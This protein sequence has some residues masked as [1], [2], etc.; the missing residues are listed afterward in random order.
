MKP[1]S[2]ASHPDMMP[3]IALLTGGGDRPY[4]FGLSTS[5]LAS[6]VGIDFIGSDDLDFPEFRLHRN[7]KFFNL[8]GNQ[9]STVTLSTKIRRVLTY[10]WKLLYYAATTDTPIFHILWNNKFET[11][12]RTLLMS[13]YRCL[14]KKLILTV[15]NVNAGKR[16][17][18]DTWLNRATLRRQYRSADHLFV[19]TEMMKDELSRDFQ[20]DQRR[21]SVIPFGINNSI[22][23]SSMTRSQARQ[24]LGV[25]DS[26]RVLLFFGNIAPYKG[27]D[28][29]VEAFQYL[30]S[31]DPR[32]KLVI[33][34]RVDAAPDYWTMIQR[35]IHE[36][37]PIDRVIIKSSFIP[38]T[39]I[40]ALFKSADALLLPYRHIYQSGVLFLG[41]S[42]GLPA[43][44]ADVD[45]FRSE[46]INGETGFLFR[47]EDPIHLAEVV[48]QYFAS[49]LYANLEDRRSQ[50]KSYATARNSWTRVAE[51]TIVQY[52]ALRGKGQREEEL[53]ESALVLS[54]PAA[55]LHSKPSAENLH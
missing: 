35:R 51:L 23:V 30:L 7:I 42:F 31:R 45:A 37:I 36:V 28:Y 4:A 22:P 14:G 34:G 13:Y 50:I 44:A 20:V 19:H 2:N 12:D 5:L 47:T 1:S 27:L 6:G 43:L 40:E 3:K 25:A 15:H 24:K 54:A 17:N 48:E 32:Y 9:C 18:T 41:Y 53:A 29:A 55:D 46:V 52:R 8:R 11:L 21:V 16:D 38:D 49:S 33:A 39:E 26:D 10:Y